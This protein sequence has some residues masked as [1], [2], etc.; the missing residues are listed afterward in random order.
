MGGLEPSGKSVEIGFG[1]TSR[2]VVG[3]GNWDVRD[4][5]VIKN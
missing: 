4:V 2:Y 3:K 1:K 5:A